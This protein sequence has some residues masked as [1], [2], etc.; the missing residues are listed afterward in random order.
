MT[1][2]FNVRHT[3]F[4]VSMEHV[5]HVVAKP[6]FHETV[7]RKVPSSN[8][9][10]LESSLQEGRYS[11]RRE[12]NLDVN[13]PDLA[14]KFL[15]EAFKLWR[16]DEWDIHSLTCRTHFKLNMPAEFRCKVSILAEG[17]QLLVNHDWEVD[18][19]VP[20]INGILAKHAESEIRR[21]NQIEFDTI[22]QEIAAFGQA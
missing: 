13:I 1:H 15:K 9:T 21:F 8:L 2:K 3:L 16:H 4:D 12:H 14:K 17:S 7:C 6:D 20:F 18:V 11:L 5:R 19:H 10:I 22:R